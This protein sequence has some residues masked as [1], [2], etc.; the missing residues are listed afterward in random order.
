DAALFG[1]LGYRF[2]A[3][4]STAYVR[5]EIGAGTLLYL[6]RRV[7]RYLRKLGKAVPEAYPAFA[8]EVLRHYPADFGKTAASWVAAHIWSHARG[9][10]TSAP[11]ANAVAKTAHACPAGWKATPAPLLRLLDAAQSDLVCVWA[12]KLLRAEHALVLRGVA[13]AWLARLGR[14]PIA[15]IHA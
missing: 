12:I 6:R 15:S 8:V 5:S 4:T 2:D 3:M 1:V 11:P 14:R 7:W 9:S 13:P 10:A